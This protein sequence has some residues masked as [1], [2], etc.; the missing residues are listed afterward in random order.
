MKKQATKAPKKAVAKTAVRKK[1]AKQQKANSKA[2]TKKKA[3][4]AKKAPSP[5][6][7]HPAQQPELNQSRPSGRLAARL[8]AARGTR[9]I[10]EIARES[11]VPL[12]T[13]KAW[14]MGRGLSAIDQLDA[15]ARALGRTLAGMVKGGR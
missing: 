1:A 2:V 10:E 4:K 5:A 3:A 12:S 13:I 8:R 9:T 6:A 14:E 15:L 7:G 11:G